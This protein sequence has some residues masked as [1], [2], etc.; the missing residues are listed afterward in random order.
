MTGAEDNQYADEEDERYAELHAERWDSIE[1]L[2]VTLDLDMYDNNQ[3]TVLKLI[4]D[5]TDDV[6]ISEDSPHIKSFLMS[7]LT[8]LMHYP[9]HMP[10][11]VRQW[12]GLAVQ[13]TMHDPA[14]AKKH[15][16]LYGKNKA[17]KTSHQ[18]TIELHT[19]KVV[20]Q[21]SQHFKKH[22][23]EGSLKSNPGA[24]YIA[25]EILHISPS[26]AESHYANIAADGLI[27][28][29]FEGMLLESLDTTTQSKIDQAIAG[30]VLA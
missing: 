30:R 20:H 8:C 21:L 13:R 12:L 23:E 19:F 28:D 27:F 22:K 15:F 25:A 9:Q 4:V 7:T 18:Q 17:D 2:S 16:H 1:K 24:Y 29:I 10:Y 26:T 6:D 14:N 11:K 3:L 5:Y